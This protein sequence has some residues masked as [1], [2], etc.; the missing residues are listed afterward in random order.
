[1]NY[2]LCHKDIPVVRFSTE[3]EEISEIFEILCKEHLPVGVSPDNEKGKTLKSQFRSWWK[4]RSIPASRQNLDTALEQLGNVT[5][6]YLIE[7]SYGLSLSD[8]YWAKPESTN[9][10][11]KDV[12]FF[13]NNF[14]DDVGKALFG[15]LNSDSTD[16]LNL[17]S[18]DNTSDG[19][20]KKKWILN[21][22]K[23]ILLKA[24]SSP[25]Y[26]E[27]FNEVLASEICGRLGIEHVEYR[28]IKSDGT[29][30]SSCPDFVSP[31]TEL[32]P[33]WHIVNTQ[34]KDNSTSNFNHLINCCRNLG[35]KDTE[36]LK[37]G[38]CNMLTV[39]FII[40]NTDRHY[41]N[42]GFLRNPDTLEWL[43]LSPVFDSG[44][45]FFHNESVFSLKN[46]YFRESSKIKA[47]PFATNQKEQMKKI[48]FRE[49]SAN[50][51][52]EKLNGIPEFFKSLIA[53]NPHIEPE[54]AE[55][56]CKILDSRI[57]ENENL[58]RNKIE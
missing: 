27:P 31:Q 26:Q 28:I 13:Q 5:T 58:F 6:D 19:W 50:L 24:G 43:G 48:P 38:I 40:A 49:Y 11:W 36:K 23:R 34:K 51:N 4:S 54:R 32:V 18:P 41:N 52:L 47:K 56:L 22:G 17:V 16:K 45:S 7:K 53:Q 9:L 39:D 46:P 3:D 33:A 42:F 29:F 30:Y 55:L 10:M 12:N 1:M 20:L 35:F 44:T 8:H 37:Q 25:Y 15:V 2:I 14:S 57:K 21:N